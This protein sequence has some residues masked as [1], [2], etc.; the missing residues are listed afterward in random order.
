MT[1]YSAQI[2][3]NPTTT[4]TDSS[5]VIAGEQ[6]DYMLNVH[7]SGGALVAQANTTSPHTVTGLAVGSYTATVQA[8]DTTPSLASAVSDPV[9]FTIVAPPAPLS[10]PTGLTVTQTS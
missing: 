8:L 7:N 1:T 2:S 9:S 6:N 4:H 3:W 5:A 10:V